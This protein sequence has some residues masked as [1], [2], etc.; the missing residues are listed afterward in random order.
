VRAQG[1]LLAQVKARS[2]S[3]AGAVFLVCGLL[4]LAG[5]AGDAKD[6]TTTAGASSTA[7][8]TPSEQVSTKA[9]QGGS[10]GVGD[11]VSRYSDC[12]S[13]GQVLGSALDGMRLEASSTFGG[14]AIACSWIPATS[15]AGTAHAAL[16]LSADPNQGADDVPTQEI[17]DTIGAAKVPDA[18][19]EAAGGMA[20]MTQSKGSL[21]ITVTALALPGISVQLTDG[22]IGQEPSL[23]GPAAVGAMKKLIG[24]S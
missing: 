7:S 6:E 14:D 8:E 24:L 3:A 13:A 1:S 12:E 15:G 5:C 20:M 4:M 23:V 18:E 2:S 11:I 21:Q 19:V 17:L 22:A 10:V 9:P 16:R